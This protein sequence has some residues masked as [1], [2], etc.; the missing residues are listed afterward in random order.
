MHGLLLFFLQLGVIIV[1]ARALGAACKRIQQPRVVGEMIAGILL[2]PSFLGWLAPDLWAALFPPASLGALQ[3]LSQTGLLL[4]MFLIGLELSPKLLRGRGH[5]ALLTSHASIIAPFMLGSILALYLYPRYSDDGVSFAGFALFMGAAMSVTAF[6]V[7]ARILTERNLL[8]T[9]LGAVTIAC[10]AVDDVSAWCLL[11]GVVVIVRATGGGEA[12]A[13]TLV[14]S[15]VYVAAM[16]WLVRPA[17]ARLETYYHNRGRLTQ[18]VVAVALLLLLASAWATEWLGI[19]ALFGAFLMGAVMPKEHGFVHELTQRFEDVTLVLLLPLFFAFT[20]L[21]TQLG[22]L[23]G[24]G[25]WLD[26]ALVI[27]VAVAGKLGGSAVAAR[28]SG[29]SWREAGALGVLMNTRGLMEL[30]ILSIGLD[31]GVISPIVFVMMVLMALVTTFMTT[32]L[33]EWIYP[34]ALIRKETI[35][36]G[37]PADADGPAVLIP[38]ALPSSG[39]ELL[40]MAQAIAPA[41]GSRLY[42]VHCRR[43]DDEDPLDADAAPAHDALRPLLEAAAAGG[44]VVR[45]MT[46]VS[47][48]FAED[49]TEVARVKGAR[50][51]VLGW[52]KPVISQSILGGA[53]YE[54]MR[55]AR[56]DVAVYV[57]RRPPPW[58][59][60]LVP[61]TGGPHDLAALELAGRIASRDPAVSLTVLQVVAPGRTASES[62]QAAAGLVAAMDPARVT[63]RLVDGEAPVDVALEELQRTPYDLVVIGA[64][65]AWELEPRLLG[66][67]HERLAAQPVSMLI[68]RRG[69]PAAVAP[70]V[71][72]AA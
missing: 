58:R 5:A 62:A 4:F 57:G 39:P 64:T 36:E 8:R 27:A 31:L 67:T 65:E 42:A 37:D 44:A 68:V 56:G 25:P 33:L 41:A 18:D 28:A 26:C 50:L 14:G 3:A 17:V 48:R 29:L 23:E 30:V 69:E 1:A 32:P 2:G 11:A 12:L 19:H 55:R 43:P 60:V 24:A 45:P 21:R 71:A 54:V 6:P 7:L 34:A 20:G 72:A 9:K 46:F 51:I 15:A 35:G 40:A 59:R 70:K 52:H 61:F 49:V 22:L 38:V 47:Q 13:F 53:V 63:P 16:L 10:A 66:A